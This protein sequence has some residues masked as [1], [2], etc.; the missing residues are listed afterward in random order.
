MEL[1]ETLNW[2][3][4]FIIHIILS[5]ENLKKMNISMYYILNDRYLQKNEYIK[6]YL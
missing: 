1:T 5:S 3:H 2:L 4:T 6:L